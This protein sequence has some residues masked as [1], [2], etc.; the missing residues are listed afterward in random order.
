[1]TF[2]ESVKYLFSLGNEVSAMKLGLDNVRTLLAELGD[3]QNKFLRVQVAGTNGKGSVCE[4]L[5]AICARAGI[6][7][8]LYTSPHLISI[9]ERV[10]IG[11]QDIGEEDFARHAATVR[12]TAEKLL[13]AGR[14][15]Y[16]P[17]FFEQVT[18]IALLAFAGA[19]V[20]LAIL[21]TGL[22]GRLDATT[23]AG[24]EI[25]AITQIDY[26]HQ[27][28]LGNTLAEIAAEKAAII[29][30]GT[31]VVVGQ[32]STE[33]KQVIY[34][35]CREVGVLPVWASTDIVIKRDPSILPV[36][37]GTFRTEHGRYPNVDL[38]GMLGEH[39]FQNASIAISLAELLRDHGFAIET[40][41]ICYGLETA[42]HPGRLEY[43]GRFLLDGAHN[44]AGAKALRDYLDEFVPHPVTLVFGAMRGKDA[45]AILETLLP[46]VDNLV[47]TKPENERAMTADEIMQFVT[48]TPAATNVFL[49]GSVGEGLSKADEVTSANGLIVVTGSLYL[50][51]EAKKTLTV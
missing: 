10:R 12:T 41:A 17:T 31:K 44:A 20:E 7:T 24:A 27:E 4:F 39:Q 34:G 14:I 43:I 35:R 32:Q 19:E 11:G 5:D 6:R 46:K 30:P 38:W 26:D 22:G 25:V 21:E 36:L 16:M 13:A 15:E 45:G 37:F 9:T 23:A 28:Y 47:L 50:V 1:M 42:R 51:G 48:P 40:D 18:V 29:R 2:A 3:P 49:T 8:G 33:A